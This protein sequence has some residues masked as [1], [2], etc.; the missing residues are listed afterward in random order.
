MKHLLLYFLNFT[1]GLLT[2]IG[3]ESQ[4]SKVNF[5]EAINFGDVTILF[6][7]VISD[8][9]CPKN[10]TCVWAGEAK[11]FVAISKEGELI[12]KKELIFHPS[13]EIDA[14]INI[15]Y[16]SGDIQ[17]SGIGLYPYPES[18]HKIKNEDYCLELKFN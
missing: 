12:E 4:I 15:V 1:V 2:L 13:S 7:K 17:I 16:K 10:V 9:R 6:E 14:Q 18:P 8:S 5:G 11:V 3:Q